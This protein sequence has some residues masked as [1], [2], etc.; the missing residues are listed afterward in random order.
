LDCG[1]IMTVTLWYFMLKCYCFIPTTSEWSDERSL[2]A[3][4]DHA[5]KGDTS[6]PTNIDSLNMLAATWLWD[7]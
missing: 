1:A 3:A 5:E 4:I 6:D 2:Q 7:D